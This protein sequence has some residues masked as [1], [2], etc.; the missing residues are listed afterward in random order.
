MSGGR[1]DRDHARAAADHGEREGVVVQIQLLLFC[2]HGGTTCMYTANT[3]QGAYDRFPSYVYFLSFHPGRIWAVWY[4]VLREPFVRN[5][6]CLAKVHSIHI[7]KSP[8]IG[9][10]K[11]RFRTFHGRDGVASHFELVLREPLTAENGGVCDSGQ[12]EV[13]V[14]TREVQETKTINVLLVF[15]RD[16][17]PVDGAFDI[18]SGKQVEGVA[19]VDGNG[20]ILGFD[21]LPFATRVILN[22]ETGDWLT[23]EKTP[24]PEVGVSTSNEFAKCD[25]L[26]RGVPGVFHVPKVVLTLDLIP[27]AAGKIVLRELEGDGKQYVEGVQDLGM[28][29]LFK[30]RHGTT[31]MGQTWLANSPW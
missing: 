15:G 22:L 30:G 7:G 28:E 3:T 2:R 21:P 12:L 19:S 27:V 13:V 4:S 5:H 31:V 10:P 11:I 14:W 18:V 23:E 20:R 16:G 9:C 29:G 6:F 24:A 26:F 8:N 17:N 1:G 25:V